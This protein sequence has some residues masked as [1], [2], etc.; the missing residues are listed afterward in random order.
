MNGQITKENAKQEMIN[1]IQESG[2][3]P[4]NFI[5]LGDMANR[6]I[7]DKSFYPMVVD[8]A[9][10]LGIADPGDLGGEVNYQ[11]LAIMIA[12]ATVAKEMMGQQGT[13]M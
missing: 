5:T 13:A 1:S 4:Q 12:F 11:N 2:I 10:K 3:N 7:Q 8:A 9:I 6:A